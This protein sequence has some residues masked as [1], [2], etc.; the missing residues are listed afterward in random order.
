MR[1]KMKEPGRADE[2]TEYSSVPLLDSNADDPDEV[3]AVCGL[4]CAACYI[5]GVLCA[6]SSPE[7]VRGK[8]VE[9]FVGCGLSN[10]SPQGTP[11]RNAGDGLGR[12]AG[13]CRGY[14]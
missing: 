13:K 11:S 2:T 8:G 7:G 9:R 1:W 10:P 4:Q 5:D 12:Q 14:L 6:T 3:C